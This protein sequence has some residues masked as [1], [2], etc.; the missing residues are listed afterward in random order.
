MARA[1][2]A[3]IRRRSGRPS[4]LPASSRRARASASVPEG[5]SVWQTARRLDVL[6]G[7]VLTASEFR[8]P[9]LA[10]VDL[11]GRTVLETVSRG[12]HLLMR[13]EDGMTLHSHLR[14]D[15]RWD[16]QQP[17]SAWRRPE[18]EARVVLRTEKT[19]A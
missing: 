14:M 16:V 8:I 10:T 7:Q 9:S 17:G 12:K 6:T 15:G 19:E 2:S 11:G 5:D 3:R 1:C 4:K 18:H 13:L